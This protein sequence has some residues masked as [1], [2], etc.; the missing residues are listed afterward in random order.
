MLY[1]PICID[2]YGFTDS[3]QMA[4]RIYTRSGEVL[5]ARRH[6]KRPTLFATRDGIFFWLNR[7]GLR[8]AHVRFVPTVHP[9]LCHTRYP[10]LA[11]DRGMCC[12]HLLWEIWQG[13][14]TP[15]MEIDHINGNI[16]DWSLDNLREVTPSENRRSARILRSLRVS[17]L[18]PCTLSRHDLLALFNQDPLRH[19]TTHNLAGDVYEGD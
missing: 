5:T 19:A 16:L 14:R 18:D 10:F 6:P 3:S 2:A 4:I 13:P 17:G 12:H 7:N 8:S 1:Q 9:K 11:G 15:G